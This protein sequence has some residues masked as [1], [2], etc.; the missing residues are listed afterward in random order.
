MDKTKYTVLTI[1]VTGAK[2]AGK[3]ELLRRVIAPALTAAGISID[4]SGNTLTPPPADRSR[5]A[6][7]VG[8]TGVASGVVARAN[9]RAPTAEDHHLVVAVPVGLFTPSLRSAFRKPA[10]RKAAKTAKKKR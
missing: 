2:G 1:E 7:E 3:T 8:R 5:G 4:V 10:K 6:D 9:E